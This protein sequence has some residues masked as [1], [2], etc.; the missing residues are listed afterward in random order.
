MQDDILY[1][2]ISRCALRDQSVLKILYERTSPY[3]NRVAF[4]ILRSEDLSN[5]VLQDSFIQV[6]Q[7]ADRYRRDLAQPLTWL[8]SIVRYR[9]LDRLA[10]EKKHSRGRDLDS[11]IA[12]IPSNKF[13]DDDLIISQQQQSFFDCLETMQERGR[14][15]IQ[16]A[17]LHG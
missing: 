12:E 16:L 2:L 5:D 9:A 15:C 8:S 3:L 13:M 6:W 7:N 4:N 14:T 1:E 17:Y 10:I 11:E